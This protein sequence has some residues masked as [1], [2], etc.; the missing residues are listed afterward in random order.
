[1]K[2]RLLFLSTW[3]I[4][5]LAIAQERPIYHVPINGTIDMGLPYYIQRVVNEAEEQ[6]AKAII[7]VHVHV[8]GTFRGN[9]WKQ[10][11][12]NTWK[13]RGKSHIIIW[14]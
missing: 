14:T 6:N 10:L 12:G 3:L 11:C 9:M 2:K 7:F 13:T 5:C 4:I 8:F 1:M